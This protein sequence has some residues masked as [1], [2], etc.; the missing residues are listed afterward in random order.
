MK[1]PFHPFHPLALPLL[2][3]AF[4]SNTTATAAPEAAGEPFKATMESLKQ[5][6]LTPAN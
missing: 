4:L 6:Q 2:G 1:A 5:Y 3:A